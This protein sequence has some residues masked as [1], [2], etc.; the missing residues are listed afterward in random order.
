MKIFLI[1]ALTADG[2]IAKH[3]S[4]PANWTSKEDKAFFRK[5]S[6]K[7]GVVVMG[8]RTY[9]TIGRPLPGR[10]NII[11]TKSPKAKTDKNL[12][13]FTKL[14]PKTLIKNLKKQGYKNIAICGGTSIYT[15]FL[16]S[17]LVNKLY[18]TIEPILFGKGVTL[19]NQSVEKKLKLVKIHKLSKQSVVLEYDI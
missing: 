7:G 1:A 10:L 8:S 18:L 3:A 13:R 12:L 19:F 9:K 5:K 15:M 6:K 17:G 2:L 11:Y 4:H 16:K 14:P